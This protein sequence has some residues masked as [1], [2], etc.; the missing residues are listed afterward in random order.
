MDIFVP[1]VSIRVAWL[2]TQYTHPLVVLIGIMDEAAGL[3][4]NLFV[5]MDYIN[6]EKKLLVLFFRANEI[7]QNQHWLAK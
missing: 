2:P 3:S 1:S 7:N 6:E 4:E 5:L